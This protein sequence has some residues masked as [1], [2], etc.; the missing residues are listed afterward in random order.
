MATLSKGKASATRRRVINHVFGWLAVGIGMAFFA[1]P[2]HAQQSGEI[3]GQV[4]DANGAGIAG[5]TVEASGDTLPQ[6]RTTTTVDNGKYRFRLLPPGTYNVEFTFADGSQQTRSIPVL[7][8]QMRT[9]LI[10]SM[11]LVVVELVM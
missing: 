5:V 4:T 7:L 9:I 1:A 10:Q 8:Q 11:Q 6:S 3:S 2:V